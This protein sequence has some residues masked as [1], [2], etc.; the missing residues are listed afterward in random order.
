MS[1]PANPIRWA[2]PTS[3]GPVVGRA[4]VPGS[5]SATARALVLA[6][7]AV[8][9]STLRG[10][11]SARDTRLMRDGLE[12]LGVM[13]TDLGR[14]VV[15]V[16]PPAEFTAATIDAGL[17]GTVLRFLP[18]LTA[19]AKGRSTFFGDAALSA[20]P[21]RPLVDALAQTG[22]QIS[23]DGALPLHVD[24]VGKVRGGLVE[25]D[26]SASS[27]FVSGMLM[28]APRF[29]E[30]L[31]LRHVGPPIP[32]RP[33]IEMTVAMMRHRGVAVVDRG[34]TWVVAP[35]PVAAHDTD[36]EPD[37]TNS[38]AFLA[39][40]MVTAGAVTL[41]WPDH[42]LQAAELILSVLEQFGAS[43][44][45][46]ASEIT[47][48]A[49][50]LT[51]A[52]VDLA[53]VSELTPVVAALA[54]L[55]TGPTRIRGVGHIRG[56]ET[57]RLA[58]LETE[59]NALGCRVVQT[60]DGLKIDPAPLTAGTFAT[61]GDHRLAHTAAIIGLVVPGVVLDDI[62]CTTKTIEGFPELWEGLVLP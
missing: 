39:A 49:S 48:G 27:Q 43:V 22:V 32:S 29:Q 6:S 42:S 28:S 24:G 4:N 56:H 53:Q 30:G 47:V 23:Y 2:A 52:D 12:K 45:R 61:Y 5:K 20:R 44:Q 51:G 18:P 50:Q 38:A 16:T 59:L 21:I 25:V 26:A 15:R 17:A 31:T 41:A 1:T 3:P 57:D 54:A 8:G 34:D 13:F 9:A 14:G 7:I 37:L 19:L 62:S 35:S 11:L 36:I 60:E 40:G 10:V 58:A 55:A 33:H 46:T